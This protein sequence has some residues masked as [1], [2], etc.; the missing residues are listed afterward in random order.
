MSRSST[1]FLPPLPH[2]CELSGIYPPLP[3]H[4]KVEIRA[5]RRKL[6][7]TCW[8]PWRHNL[9]LRVC[10]RSCS[11]EYNV[12]YVPCSVHSLLLTLHVC[13]CSCSVEYNVSHVPCSVH[14]LL[15]TLHV[16]RCSCS[17]EYNVSHVPCS[18][19][20][21]L[22]T[23]HVCQCSCSVEYNVSYVYHALFAYFDR[24]NVGLPGFAK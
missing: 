20:S 16:C 17:V 4:R 12:S 21:L 15:L 2:S 22:L 19:H 11:V 3:L 18:V 1:R 24:D 6:S 13:R 7:H 23:L 8:Q 10:Q 14:S 9:L 5:K